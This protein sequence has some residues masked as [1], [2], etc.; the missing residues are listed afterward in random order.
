M[1]NILVVG[2]AGFIGSHV[3]KML[4]QAG[5]QPIILDNLSTGSI[6]AV[7][8]G[9]FIQG[10]MA[11][12]DVLDKIFQS[13]AIS[14]VMHF[15]ALTDVGES[16][17]DPQKYYFNNV[18]TTVNLL[19]A[20]I[21]YQ[22]KVFIF[23]SSAAIFGLP[24]EEYISENHPCRP[25]NPYGKSKLMVEEILQDYDR[26]YGLRFCCLRYFN[27]AGGDPDNEIKNYKKK[28]NNLIPVILRSL[29][30]GDGAVTI[31]G[32]DYP[33]PD[34]TC[35]RDYIHVS[36]L[37]AAHLRALEQLFERKQ[38]CCF[39]LG[40]GRGFS[41]REVI[42]VAEQVTNKKLRIIEGPRREGDPPVLLA[43][44]AHAKQTLRWEPQYSDLSTMVKHAWQALSV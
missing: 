6:N 18:V 37:G 36:D 27:A 10:D 29:K 26:S 5:Y 4:D 21:K 22:V 41:V 25:I 14:A 11:D 3:V 32:N 19:C 33:T 7:T 43:N 38:S 35:I 34:G 16:I 39:N 23:S 31:F 28:E 8:R 40:N 15:A 20:M 2:G 9:I 1:K 44:G 12:K 24:L 30:F 17:T 42:R 13:H